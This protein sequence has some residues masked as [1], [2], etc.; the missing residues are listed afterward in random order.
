LPVTL[1]FVQK[2]SLPSVR[3]SSPIYQ[4]N[5]ILTGN[6]VTVIEGRFDINGSIIV[7]ENATLILRN[8]L[9]NFTEV[10]DFQ[11]NM[12]FQNPV[13]GNP[14]LMVE[15]ATI[16]SN[17]FGLIVQFDGNSSAKINEL[18][19]TL[20]SQLLL[21]SSSSA[22]VEDS[23]GGYINLQHSSVL[24][25][26][27]SSFV[28]LSGWDY[29]IVTISNCTLDV[30]HAEGNAVFTATNCTI[31]NSVEISP[32]S[33]NC[34]VTGLASGYISY[35]S[36]KQNCSVA[37]PSIGATPNFTLTDTRVGGWSFLTWGTSNTSISNS[38]LYALH[39]YGFSAFSIYNSAISG[40][41]YGWD[42]SRWRLY[43]TTAY[44]LYSF[45][46]SRF[47][48]TNS[49]SNYYYIYDHSEIYVSWYLDAHI[50]D[51]IGQ[52]VPSANVAAT[53][54]NT[55]V[56][57]SQLTNS[58]GWARLTLT[59]KIMN[60]S[61]RYPVG[62][63]TVE[64]A[65]ESYSDNAT[66]SM[67]GNKQITLTLEGLVIPEFPSLTILPLFMVVTLLAVMVYKRKQFQ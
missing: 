22:L 41:L 34:S 16:T 64:A 6:N 28:E 43:D 13:N 47:W 40:Y 63:Y 57:E 4:G 25:M 60:A 23:T 33:T 49:T 39:A 24:T 53:H 54:P 58:S 7:K 20:Y 51:S 31:N 36:F 1:A 61:G 18:S 32:L 38:E 50:V 2:G 17:S 55:I 12:T 52:D 66:M 59:E 45:D 65:Y 46:N 27:D 44:G 42:S 14:R 9:V 5:L 62:N 30:L 26:S 37:V 3:A 21:C 15:N 56:A 48:L 35:W 11:F 8:A 67:A 19:A 10:E 29:P